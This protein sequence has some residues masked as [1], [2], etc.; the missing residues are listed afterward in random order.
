MRPKMLLFTETKAA[1]MVYRALSTYFDK[2]IEF[3]MVKKDDEELVK[4][5]KVKKFP[6]FVLLKPG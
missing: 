5:Y 1:P 3:G 6:T 2:T 4:Q